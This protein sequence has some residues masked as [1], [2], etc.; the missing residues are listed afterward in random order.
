MIQIRDSA[1]WLQ[2]DDNNYQRR[3]WSYLLFCDEHLNRKY[4]EEDE[5][6]ATHVVFEHRQIQGSVLERGKKTQHP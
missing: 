1:T 3:S 5:G 4:A 6:G 2:I